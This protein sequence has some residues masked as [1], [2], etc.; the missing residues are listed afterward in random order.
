MTNLVRASRPGEFENFGGLLN[1]DSVKSLEP[2]ANF[3][4]L[5]DPDTGLVVRR[6]DVEKAADALVPSLPG[7]SLLYAYEDGEEVGIGQA[8]I[9][10]WRVSPVLGHGIRPVIHDA[11]D[12]RAGTGG[13]PYTFAALLPDG[14]VFSLAES[15]PGFEYR[16][17]AEY[18][19]ATTREVLRRREG[20]ARR[21]A[22]LAAR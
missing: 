3:G 17:R 16:S 5:R 11:V 9:V 18:E 7:W 15:D 22:K 13:L 8:I 14:R 2:T 4:E 20:A 1:L 21:K 19:E 12:L 6:E 10:A